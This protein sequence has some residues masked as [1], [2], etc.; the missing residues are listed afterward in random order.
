[1]KNSS[2]AA[3]IVRKL[4]HTDAARLFDA[5]TQPEL[6]VRWWGPKGVVCIGAEVD[7]RVGGR[8]RIGNRLPDGS[9]LW[10]GGLFETI[11]RPRLLVY[12][13]VL[14]HKPDNGERVSVHFEPRGDATEVIV[15]HERIA[16]EATRQGHVDGWEGCLDGLERMFLDTS[17]I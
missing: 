9:E 3:L 10:I 12:S 6:L 16:D 5:W 13:W 2:D 7:L 17:A 1:M 8:Y 11:N 14:E 4:V 15:V